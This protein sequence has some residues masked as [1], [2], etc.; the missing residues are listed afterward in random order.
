MEGTLFA[1]SIFEKGLSGPDS[2]NAEDYDTFLQENFGDDSSTIK[3]AYPLSAFN[4]TPYPAFY[5]MSAVF[6]DHEF[7]CPA[8]RAL[9]ATTAAGVPVW[10]YLFAHQPKCP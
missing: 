5:A 1:F 9:D 10:T 6:T 4:S 3:Q 8:R 7:F 2:I